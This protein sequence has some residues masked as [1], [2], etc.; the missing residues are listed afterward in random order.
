MNANVQDKKKRS[1]NS[2][3]DEIK[4]MPVADVFVKFQTGKEGLSADK[5]RERLEQYGPNA[6]KEEKTN[7]LI[8]FLRYF[9]GPI[10]WMIDTVRGS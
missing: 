10:P 9:W 4:V 5:A 8:K 7:P 3:L 1:G 2:D 6:L